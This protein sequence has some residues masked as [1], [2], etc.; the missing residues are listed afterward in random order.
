MRSAIALF[1]LLVLGGPVGAAD[2][3]PAGQASRAQAIA[4]AGTRAGAWLQ[5]HPAD[6]REHDVI[7]VVEEIMLYYAL[8][9][10]VPDGPKSRKYRR[11]IFSRHQS[12]V[13]LNHQSMSATSEMRSY[14]QGIWGPLTYP[15]AAYIVSQLG[16]DASTYYP[17][18]D[19]I[20][21][22]HPLL[23]PPR[24]SM[25]TWIWVY[26]ERLGHPPAPSLAAVVDQGAL[27]TE[28]RTHALRDLLLNPADT[29]DPQAII[30]AIYDITH[31]I[32]ALTDFGALPPTPELAADTQQN[33]ALLDAGIRWATRNDAT[34]ILA[35][36]IFAAHLLGLDELPSLPAA[37]SYILDHQQADGS[38]GITNPDR[39]E[40]RRHGVL[41]CLL[42]L[43]SVAAA[44]RP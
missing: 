6:I 21:N 4:T 25:R 14:L 42:A 10:L 9:R 28:V 7:G 19:D 5:A 35:E 36:Q 22:H 17:I 11:E 13:D 18:V 20:L 2:P 34:D 3:T 23:Y 40:G 29:T 38:F 44:Q 26:M 27:H 37:V 24:A 1:V 15:P 30:Q 43:E 12:L 8:D 39:P 32:L 33:A 31:E 41:T 16:L